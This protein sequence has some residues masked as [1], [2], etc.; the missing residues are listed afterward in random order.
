MAAS[1]ASEGGPCDCTRLLAGASGFIHHQK[2]SLIVG[3][4]DV[5]KDRGRALR[6]QGVSHGVGELVRRPS[7]SRERGTPSS[8][9]R[10]LALI[11]GSRLFDFVFQLGGQD[12]IET[13]PGA[14][15]LA[16]A[17]D[18]AAFDPPTRPP[19]RFPRPNHRPQQVR[20]S[21]DDAIRGGGMSLLRD[22]VATP[23]VI[24][25]DRKRQ[26]KSNL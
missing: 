6:A 13:G 12:G 21:L 5:D 2:H 20:V 10:R 14:D 23:P 4:V 18:C 19:P 7:N 26:T 24:G 17:V 8:G 1:S 15:A 11:L 3:V 9:P 25:D 22:D 16:G